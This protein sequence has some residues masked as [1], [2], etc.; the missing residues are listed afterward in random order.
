MHDVS[1]PNLDRGAGGKFPIQPFSE[2]WI[3]SQLLAATPS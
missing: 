2:F 3:I 1:L